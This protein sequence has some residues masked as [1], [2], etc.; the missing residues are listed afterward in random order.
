MSPEAVEAAILGRRSVRAFRPDPVD[1]ALVER[2][3]ALAAR[4]PSGTNMQPWRAYVV[5]G[6]ARERLC[7]A[8]LAAHADPAGGHESE[9][10]YYPDPF[11]DPYGAR[12]RKVGLDLYGLLGIGRGE[13][14]RMHAQHGRNL[15]FFGAPVG[16]IFTIDRRLAIGS[17]LDYGGF[18]QSLMIAARAYG[19]DTCPQAAFA[20][21]HRVIRAHLPISEGEIVVCGM[22]LGYADETAPETRLVT[23]R[24]PVADFATF[25]DEPGGPS[26]PA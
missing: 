20:P 19:L 1:R 13:G 4:A 6:A 14:E 3:L 2:L 26:A 8:L 23:E 9:Y 12:R 10:R 25:L 5:T 24:A 18:L 22:A 15:A 11:P 21:F 17:W 7:A 16:L